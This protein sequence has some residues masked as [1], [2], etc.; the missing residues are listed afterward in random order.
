MVQTIRVS[1]PGYDA[2]TDTNPDHYALYADND[3]VL[4]KEKTR[5]TVSVSAYSISSPI[6]HGLPYIPYVL[7]FVDEGGGSY[8]RVDGKTYD[9]LYEFYIDSSNIYFVNNSSSTK[10]FYYYIFYDGLTGTST[11][12]TE[13]DYVIKI[14]KS[15]YDVLTEKNPNNYIFHSDLNTFKM[16]INSTYS[17]TLTASTTNQTFSVP[18]GLSFTPFVT[19]FASEVGQS[20]VFLPNSPDVTSNTWISWVDT[21]VRFNYVKSD[22]TNIIFN[23]DNTSTSSKNII[24]RYY[25]L[26]KIWHTN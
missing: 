20:R 10:I 8:K 24:I 13:S 3:L 19:A 17:V 16:I 4:L 15:G 1:L 2:L 6:P 21:G 26:E 9:T 14:T 12:F 25:C 11:T 23:F 18:H 5:G 22:A 7:S